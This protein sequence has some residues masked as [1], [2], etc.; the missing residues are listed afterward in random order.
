[1]VVSA[2]RT[3]GQGDGPLRTAMLGNVTAALV[4]SS[5][6]R[7]LAPNGVLGDHSREASLPK[8]QHSHN[9][10]IGEVA[11]LLNGFIGD[12]ASVRSLDG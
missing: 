10:H 3:F 6:N 9:A 4:G 12:P 2:C 5:P 7:K 1:M 8:R 11:A